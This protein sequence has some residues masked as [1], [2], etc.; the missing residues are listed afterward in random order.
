MRTVAALVAGLIAAVVVATFL[1]TTQSREP[2]LVVEAPDTTAADIAAIGV[3]V[4]ELD[5]ACS[6]GDVDRAMAQYADDAVEM[7]ANEPVVVGKPAIRARTANNAEIYDDD[8][9]STVEDV[10]ISGELAFARVRY[11]EAWTLKAARTTTSVVG[12][13]VFV[14]RRQADGSWKIETLIWNFDA[15]LE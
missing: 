8:L 7:P 1:W 14:L 4:R 15:P 3:V 11:A 12:K 9:M 10:Q 2:Q 5:E 6:A 13:S